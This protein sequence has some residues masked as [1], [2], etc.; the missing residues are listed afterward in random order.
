MRNP[1]LMRPFVPRSGGNPDTDGDRIEIRD[2]LRD[3]S[4]TVVENRLPIPLS[5]EDP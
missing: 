1:V 2:L 5:S 4:D 3:H